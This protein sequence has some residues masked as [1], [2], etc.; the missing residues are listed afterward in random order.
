MLLAVVLQMVK[1]F[2]SGTKPTA[3]AGNVVKH[4]SDSQHP[5]SHSTPW[6]I[7][8]RAGYVPWMRGLD[9][10]QVAFIP[11]SPFNVLFIPGPCQQTSFFTFQSTGFTA[12]SVVILKVA[13]QS[14]WNMLPMC[15]VLIFFKDNKSGWGNWVPQALGNDDK[16]ND[17]HM[18]SQ[19]VA[20]LS[21]LPLGV[22]IWWFWEQGYACFQR[23][24]LEVNAFTV[25]Q[26]F[27]PK[28]KKK[29]PK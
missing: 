14:G 24:S 9:S 15:K 16:V 17:G 23:F 8:A 6:Q 13:R 11:T 2:R 25:K 27:R 20:N 21:S 7:K 26:N 10:E 29:T 1:C 4:S 5:C 18:E 19:I 28:Q 3:E 22:Q 12:W